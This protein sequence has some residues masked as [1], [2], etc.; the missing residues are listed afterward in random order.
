MPF[1]KETMCLRALFL[2]M[3]Y[4]MRTEH[5]QASETHHAWAQHSAEEAQGAPS[6]SSATA[7]T[8]ASGKSALQP[9]EHHSGFSE[10][11]LLGWRNWSNQ[12]SSSSPNVYLY[13]T[14]PHK[15]TEIQSAALLR[16]SKGG[17]RASSVRSS[18]F[19][20]SKTILVFHHIAVVITAESYQ[21]SQE[22]RPAAN[23]HDQPSTIT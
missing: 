2:V 12:F 6:C 4:T 8:P 16:D 15:H 9:Q 19:E 5:R 7:P 14:D 10:L 3:R 20:F 23:H 1:Y 22:P 21:L 17:K 13:K 18:F 11:W